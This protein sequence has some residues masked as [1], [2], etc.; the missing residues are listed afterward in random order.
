[1]PSLLG[2]CCEYMERAGKKMKHCSKFQLIL[3]KVQL[4]TKTCLKELDLIFVP[5]ETWHNFYFE[6]QRKTYQ[7]SK[8][9]LINISIQMTKFNQFLGPNPVP[10]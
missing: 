1:M 9:V 4:R 2:N 6:P 5:A 8:W 10:A 7:K 3:P